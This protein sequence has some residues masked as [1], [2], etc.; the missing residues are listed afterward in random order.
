M[1]CDIVFIGP[2]APGLPV[3]SI[4]M[5]LLPAM[6]QAWLPGRLRVNQ[7]AEGTHGSVTF[8]CSSN[9]SMKPL[10]ASPHRFKNR[11]YPVTLLSCRWS[12]D[13]RLGLMMRPR[14]P[15]SSLACA[16]GLYCW[17]E[18]FAPLTGVGLPRH[19]Q[20]WSGRSQIGNPCIGHSCPRYV[21]FLKHR[22]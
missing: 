15:K 3:A 14:G 7:G 9:L 8:A 10:A 18:D 13:Q 12:I 17:S 16:S 4:L 20:P 19:S 5:R 22:H 1:D 11:C 2:P 21:D 6:L